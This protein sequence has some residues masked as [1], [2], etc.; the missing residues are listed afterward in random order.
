[1]FADVGSMNVQSVPLFH[2]MLAKLKSV[3]NSLNHINIALV[4]ET[5][6]EQREKT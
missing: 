4:V 6:K 5:K 1:M 2:L 3:M